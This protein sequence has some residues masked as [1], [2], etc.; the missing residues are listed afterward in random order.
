MVFKEPI[1][2]IK[3]AFPLCLDFES[4]FLIFLFFSQRFLKTFFCLLIFFSS[5]WEKKLFPKQNKT[6]NFFVEISQSK[7]SQLNLRS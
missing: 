6:K 1:S 5:I 7:T 4:C 3:F 2:K